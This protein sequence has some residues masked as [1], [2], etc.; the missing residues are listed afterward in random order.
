MGFEVPFRS[1]VAEIITKKY[2]DNTSFINEIRNKLNIAKTSSI[3]LIKSLSRKKYTDRDLEND[4]TLLKNVVENNG[5]FI[6]ETETDVPFLSLVLLMTYI[7]EDDFEE[8]Y[9]RIGSHSDYVDQASKYGYARNKLSHPRSK[10]LEDTNLVPVLSFVKDIC[11]FLDDKFF[12][13]KKRED[14]IALMI[15]L[16]QYRIDIPFNNNFGEMPDVGSILVCRDHEIQNIKDF[17]YGRKGDLRKQHSLCIYGHGGVGKTSLVIEAI[18]QIVGDIVD[19]TVLNGYSPEYILFFSA[20][21]RQLNIKNESGTVYEEKKKCQFQNDTELFDLIRNTL[22]IDDFRDFKKEGLVIVD[23]LESLTPEERENV[24]DYVSTKTPAEMQFIITSRNSE[25]YETNL[26]LAGFDSKNG[27]EFIGE[28]ITENSLELDLTDNEKEELIQI[29]QGNTLVLVL[30]LRRLSLNLFSFSVLKTEYDSRNA[31]KKLL[32][33]KRKTV[34]NA[35][36][37]VADFM[38]QDTFEHLEEMFKANIGGF[39]KVLEVFSVVQNGRVDIGTICMLTEEQ[40]NYIEEVIE[41]LCNYLIIERHEMQYELNGFAEKYI[42]NRFLPDAET[43]ERLSKS[44]IDKNREIMKEL[45]SLDDQV[46]KNVVMAQ[47]MKDWHINTDL[48]KIAAAKLFRI[49]GEIKRLCQNQDRLH[50]ESEVEM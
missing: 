18:K 13:E 3:Q 1:Y 16:Q 10:T 35:Y 50:F 25:N 19:D 30:S 21:K 38:Y 47:I 9:N 43:V 44:I 34:T 5:N 37:V 7:L 31:W 29:S 11:A 42:I 17:V 40:Y 22:E 15:S 41:V 46:A 36:E 48:D 49:Y 12:V 26:K 27:H 23:N 33:Y 32:E 39:Y 45:K 4:Y 28:Y 2:T 8:L 14:L 24:K 20:K 6:V